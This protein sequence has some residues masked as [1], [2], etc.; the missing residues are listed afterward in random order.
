MGKDSL[1]WDRL[2]PGRYDR[3][4][5]V[6]RLNDGR[7]LCVPYTVLAGERASPRVVVTAGVHGDEYCHFRL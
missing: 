1:H 3:T 6:G 7:M 4:L 5:P 2:A